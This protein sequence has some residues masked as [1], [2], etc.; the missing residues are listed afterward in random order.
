MTE[1]EWL[2]CDNPKHLLRHLGCT[3]SERKRRLFGCACC[4]R[5]WHLIA[6][7][8]S[9]AAVAVAEKFTD[10]GCN[11]SELA[12]A[13]VQ[14]SAAYE[15]P[16]NSGP[17]YTARYTAAACLCGVMKKPDAV[18]AALGCVSA[19]QMTKVLWATE[20]VA[21]CNLVREIF[22]NPFRPVVFSSSWRTDTALTLARQMYESREFSAMPILADAL[23][24][25]GCDNEDI[26]SHCRDANQVHVRGCW[27]V[28]LVLGKE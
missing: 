15:D 3:C 20:Q 13:E 5:V 1:E 24:D 8:R 26:L 17:P 27:V 22:G 21:Q 14:A 9:R 25:A 16:K 28:D 19:T 2:T 11:S 6:D 4:R 23:Q 7:D 10:G 12:E 18:Q